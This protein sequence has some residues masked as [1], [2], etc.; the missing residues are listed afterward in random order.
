MKVRNLVLLSEDSKRNFA[1]GNTDSGSGT[2]AFAFDVV[3]APE[4]NDW[5]Y[6]L[7]LNAKVFPAA[8]GVEAV[9][10]ADFCYALW[11]DEQIG[12]NFVLEAFAAA[13]P[14]VRAD[15]VERLRRYDM[16]VQSVP[17]SLVFEKAN[18]SPAE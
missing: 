15:L 10:A 5:P 16:S 8:R 11:V 14:F 6:E 12:E 4:G 1:T 18:D 13:W 2:L 7:T 17:L 3:S 9:F